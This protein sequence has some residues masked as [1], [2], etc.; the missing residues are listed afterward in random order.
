M[1][2]DYLEL[3]GHDAEDTGALFRPVKTNS[4]GGLNN[5]IT[6]DGVY[7]LVRAY[8]V[9]LGFKIGAHSLRPTAA[10]NALDHQA[11]ITKV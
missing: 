8:S 7:R 10:T 9:E 3:V 1:I 11:D 2:H 5:A 6:P 4:G